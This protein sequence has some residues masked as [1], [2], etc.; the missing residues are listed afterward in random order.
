M[1]AGLAAGAAPARPALAGAG[2]P[3]SPAW[4]ELS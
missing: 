4:V 1:P 2:A 3:A